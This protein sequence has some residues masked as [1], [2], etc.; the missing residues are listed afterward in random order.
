MEVTAILLDKE[1]YMEEGEEREGRKQNEKTA[2]QNE[3]ANY[4]FKTQE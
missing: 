3:S 2:I 1:R 4:Y